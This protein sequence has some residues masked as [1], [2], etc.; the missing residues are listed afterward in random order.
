MPTM[1]LFHDAANDD[2]PVYVAAES[3]V[4]VRPPATWGPE[5]PG[6]AM[7]ALVDAYVL[8]TVE[9]VPTVLD[10]IAGR[11]SAGQ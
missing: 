9:D 4:R 5:R 1:L 7:L 11:N 8:R 3:I 10:I 2:E 6:E